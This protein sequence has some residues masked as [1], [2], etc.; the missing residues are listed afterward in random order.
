VGVALARRI[1]ALGRTARAA[2]GIRTRQPVAAVRLK[3][4]TVAATRGSLAADA[5]LAS[6]L[7]EQILEELNAKR[8]ELLSDESEMIERT[9]YP[10]LPVIGPRHGAAAGRILAAARAGEW[11]L[12]GDGRATLAGVTLMPDEFELHARPRPGHELAQEG[13]LLLALETRLDES[14][15]AE[16]QAREV[17]HRLQNLRRSA[18]YAVSDR[19]GATVWGDPL[20]IRRLEAFRE[21]LAQETLSTSLSLE[22][23][24]VADSSEAVRPGSAPR[25]DAEERVN[26]DGARLYLSVR[27]S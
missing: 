15:L 27:R 21:W 22:S 26:L 12:T 14:L 24:P 3:L 17:A 13:D 19:I 18:G 10:L 2:S 6:A 1:V 7:E 20:I 23:K 16:G 4:P 9:L 5:T 25:A 11:Q 8:L